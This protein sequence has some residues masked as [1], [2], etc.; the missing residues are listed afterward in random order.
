MSQQRPDEA[1][2]K[3]GHSPSGG[4][5]LGQLRGLLVVLECALS[6]VLLTGA[7][8]LIR[9]F[10]SLNSVNPGFNS[11]GVLLLRVSLAKNT[12]NDGAQ[13]VFTQREAAFHE[14]SERLAGVPGV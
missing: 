3:S 6:V 10:Q 1:L 8:L 14:I 2:K 7:G 5:R 9:S 11:D 4:L 13:S 12:G